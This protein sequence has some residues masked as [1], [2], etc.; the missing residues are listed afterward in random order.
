[1]ANRGKANGFE[2]QQWAG[3]PLDQMLLWLP[4][5]GRFISFH[6]LF[7]DE[8]TEGFQGQEKC[9]SCSKQAMEEY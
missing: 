3:T 6:I 5:T 8:G 7:K 4:Y 9:I 2:C 1:M